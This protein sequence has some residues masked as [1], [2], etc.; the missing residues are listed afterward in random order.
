MSLFG[1]G[2]REAASSEAPMHHYR[3]FLRPFLTASSIRLATAVITLGALVERGDGVQRPL[4]DALQL[5]DAARLE[6]NS[7][8]CDEVSHRS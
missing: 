1:A 2:T 3:G 8:A 4:A 6:R 7:R 5:S